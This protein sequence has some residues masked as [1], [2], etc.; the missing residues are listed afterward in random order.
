MQ[1]LLIVPWMFCKTMFRLN[2]KNRAPQKNLRQTTHSLFPQL[3]SARVFCWRR[4][5]GCNSDRGDIKK[6]RSEYQIAGGLVNIDV[7]FQPIWH[8]KQNWRTFCKWQNKPSTSLG[9]W[10]VKRS[11]DR[12][13]GQRATCQGKPFPEQFAV[14]L[15]I[16]GLAFIH[17]SPVWH[18]F[19]SCQEQPRFEFFASSCLRLLALTSSTFLNVILIHLVMVFCCICMLR[20]CE[21]CKMLRILHQKVTIAG[22]SPDRVF[23]GSSWTHLYLSQEKRPPEAVT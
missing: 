3:R 17:T 21:G 5:T 7:I 14:Q 8:D 11:H 23:L 16:S 22:H 18:L 10:K 13:G 19:L 20:T 15:C 4:L 9:C 6:R 2:N 1:G 12:I